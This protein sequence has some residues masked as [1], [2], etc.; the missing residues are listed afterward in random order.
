MLY[1]QFF[2]EIPCGMANSVDPDQRVSQGKSDLGLHYLHIKKFCVTSLS[3]H[4]AT[5]TALLY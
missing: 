2:L 4:V 1:V 3:R 5:C